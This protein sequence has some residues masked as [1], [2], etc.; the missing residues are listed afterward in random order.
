LHAG[1]TFGNDAI[2]LDAGLRETPEIATFD[3]ELQHVRDAWPKL[4]AALR[5]GILAMIDAARK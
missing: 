3:A 1:K 2:P 5:A 4:P